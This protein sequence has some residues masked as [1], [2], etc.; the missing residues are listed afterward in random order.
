MLY[1][2]MEISVCIIIMNYNILII[3]K[4]PKTNFIFLLY[5]NNN[6]VQDYYLR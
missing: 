6:V 3:K 5:E 4:R 2:I 1:K